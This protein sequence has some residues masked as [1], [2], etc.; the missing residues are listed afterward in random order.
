MLSSYDGNIHSQSLDVDLTEGLLQLFTTA[1][2]TGI[3]IVCYILV[4]VVLL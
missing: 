4:S 2:G 3:P 1:G